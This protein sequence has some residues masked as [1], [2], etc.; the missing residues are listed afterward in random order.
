M[1]VIESESDLVGTRADLEMTTDV[2]RHEAAQFGFCSG[3][4]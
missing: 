1:S 4:F 2:G 3:L